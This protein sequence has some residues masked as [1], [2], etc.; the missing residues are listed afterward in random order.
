MQ[1][2]KITTGEDQL[3]YSEVK[4]SP[5]TNASFSLKYLTEIPVKAIS[6]ISIANQN[7]AQRLLFDQYTAGQRVWV[8]YNSGNWH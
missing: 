4:N 8:T 3:R 5:Y 7:V 2:T 1:I 6:N